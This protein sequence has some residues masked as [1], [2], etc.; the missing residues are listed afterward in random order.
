MLL[1]CVPFS[2]QSRPLSGRVKGVSRNWRRLPL[3][4]ARARFAPC[5][6]AP[7]RTRRNLAGGCWRAHATARSARLWHGA[8]VRGR[9][10]ASSS[11]KDCRTTRP[12]RAPADVLIICQPRMWSEQ[13]N[14]G[15]TLAEV[16]CSGAFRCSAV[17]RRQFRTSREAERCLPVFTALPPCHPSSIDDLMTMQRAPD[18]APLPGSR[19]NNVE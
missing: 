15:T 3:G 6:D 18:F 16:L 12:P 9:A 13:R 8:H 1:A 4:L 11:A 5:R 2:L 7:G 19:S 14:T 17:R 10:V